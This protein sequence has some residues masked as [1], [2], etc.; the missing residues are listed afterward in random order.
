MLL[1]HSKQNDACKPLIEC[2][3]VILMWLHVTACRSAG[4]SKSFSRSSLQTDDAPVLTWARFLINPMNSRYRNSVN[5]S[6][7]LCAKSSAVY[8]QFK[9]RLCVWSFRFRWRTELRLD[10]FPSA[11]KMLAISVKVLVSLATLRRL[12]I[13]DRLFGKTIKNEKN[14]NAKSTRFSVWFIRWR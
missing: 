12:D 7:Q 8:P 11:N 3:V 6:V 14:K 5:I 4:W 1:N 10:C 9:V 13:K 2:R